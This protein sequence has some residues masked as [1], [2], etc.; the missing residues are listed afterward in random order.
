[1]PAN[2]NLVG[3]WKLSG[4]DAE[5]THTT[6]N[7]DMESGEP[8]HS[9]SEDAVA[10]GSVWYRWTAP[11]D[12]VVNVSAVSDSETIGVAAY[13]GENFVD[14]DTGQLEVGVNKSITFPVAE[15][16]EYFIAVRGLPTQFDLELHLIET[17]IIGTFNGAVSLDGLNPNA[18]QS[19]ENAFKEPGEPLHA[20]NSG[21]RS[22]WFSWVA[23]ESGNLT[24]STAGSDF[25][26]LLAV[27]QG[28]NLTS[29]L[30]L[31]SND[32]FA[33]GIT[34][35]VSLPVSAGETY[36]IAVDGKYDLLGNTISSGN[37]LLDL[38]LAPFNDLFVN[39]TFVTGGALL[40]EG[41][42]NNAGKEGSELDHAGN[43]GGS[44]VWY[45]YI[46]PADGMVVVDTA[47]SEIDT[48]LAVYSGD[49]IGGL[50]T[51]A[52]N[53]NLGGVIT[54]SRVV[55]LAEAGESYKFA[56]D[57]K[58]GEFGKF[59]LSLF[60]ISENDDFA[61]RINL[62]GTFASSTGVTDFA[63][64]EV[65]E[66]I[67]G[68]NVGGRSIWWEWTAPANGRVDLDTSASNFDTLLAIYTGSS[69]TDLTEVASNDNAELGKVVSFLSTPV[70]GSVTP[71]VS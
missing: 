33:P 69:I 30:A 37:V 54:S 50:S 20:N 26:T 40:M 57:G 16:Q 47:G 61:N 44:S 22:I 53:D 5:L 13:V 12:G 38:S 64:H 70:F 35:Q 43:G 21:G 18:F 19:N 1:M 17:A 60:M 15:A 52:S 29:L 27:Y 71:N 51:I 66:P 48:L 67:H 10:G 68:G 31:A 34:S 6:F 7:A 11:S 45:N 65:G 58:N 39:A 28:A 56:I 9:T 62:S 8:S 23:P 55:I 42:S 2:N 25:D 24:A 49:A 3:A 63:T 46:A 32:D 4:A 36:F 14:F 41:F 59:I